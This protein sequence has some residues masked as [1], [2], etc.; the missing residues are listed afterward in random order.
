MKKYRKNSDTHAK[1]TKK[2]T[3]LRNIVYVYILWEFAKYSDAMFYFEVIFLT[4]L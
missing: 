2:Q 4:K 1:R 3:Q